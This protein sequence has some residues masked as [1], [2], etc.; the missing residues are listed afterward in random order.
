[1]K[2]TRKYL[3]AFIV[4]AFIVSMVSCQSGCTT[5]TQIQANWKAMKSDEKAR[6]VCEFL[7]SELTTLF[8]TG[9]TYVDANPSFQPTWKNQVVPSFNV[10]NRALA[11]YMIQA[12]AD[13]VGFLDVMQGMIPLITP[14]T[15][16]LAGWGIDVSSI[17]KIIGG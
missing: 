3:S 5:V 11:S 17:T 8:D 6:V 12:K 16:A 13:K 2:V 9:K 4:I 1:M 7:Q 14:I 10:A 15:K